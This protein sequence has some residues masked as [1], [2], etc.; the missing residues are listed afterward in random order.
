VS[1]T[2]ISKTA[3]VG[4]VVSSATS[5]YGGGSTIVTVADLS[6]VRM[7]ALVNE[8]DVGNVHAGMPVTVTVDA[9]PNRRFA[10]VVERVEPQATVESSVTMFP[11]LVS[12][13]NVDEAL[14]PGMNGEV[15]IV[16]QQRHNV[17]AV[18]NDAIRGMRDL[19]LAAAALGLNPDSAMAAARASRTT[20]AARQ[21]NT[22]GVAGTDSQRTG[23]RRQGGSGMAG[24]MTGGAGMMAAVG[25]G[26]ASP[27]VVFVKTG[28]T[29]TPK[30][31][32]TGASDFDYSE[33]LGGNLQEGDQV[34]L[35]GA[36]LIQAQREAQSDRIR[37]MTGGGLPGTGSSSSRSTT[38]SRS[39]ASTSTRGSGSSGAT[40][41]TRS[42][43]TSSTRDDNNGGSSGGASGSTSGGRSSNGGN[44]APPPP[45]G[46]GGR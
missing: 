7:R 20:G 29:W 6:R 1:G 40:T 21:Q 11:V 35:L 34:A 28:T 23:T 36:A 27:Q 31:I 9:F 45:N 5:T 16:T 38:S 2:I 8:T 25:G 26:A 32:R 42:G 44:T 17:L 14:L 46:G 33:V 43:S 24:G 22:G 30:I 18:P 41:G 3:S 4:T 15:T 12:L 19:P 39:G 10:G 13:Q 37:S